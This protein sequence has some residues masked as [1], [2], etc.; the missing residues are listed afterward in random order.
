MPSFHSSSQW[1]KRPGRSDEEQPP[2]RGLTID[3]DLA[4]GFL[5][6]GPENNGKRFRATVECCSHTAFGERQGSFNANSV[7]TA[8]IKVFGSSTAQ[9]FVYSLTR[10]FVFPW[11]LCTKNLTE[12]YVYLRH[13]K[14]CQLIP[15]IHTR[16]KSQQTKIDTLLTSRLT[17]DLHSISSQSRVLIN[18]YEHH[19]NQHLMACM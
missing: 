6:F 4:S 7:F 9:A 2:K 8:R 5:C 18:S 11:A 19:I 17:L 12:D 16:L 14:C 10:P 13:S 1:N 15:S 3:L